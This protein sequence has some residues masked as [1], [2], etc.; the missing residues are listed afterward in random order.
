MRDKKILSLNEKKNFQILAISGGGYRG[1]YSAL[2]L[3]KI[4]QKAGRP[5]AQCFDLICGTSI[6]GIIALAIGME[7]PMKD[8]VQM[9][10]EKGPKIF[11]KPTGFFSRFKPANL[12][13]AFRSKYPQN[14]LKE[15]LEGI[16]ESHIVGDIAVKGHRV[17]IPSVN[18]TQSKPQFF[19]TPH[20]E[21]FSNDLYLKLVDVSLATSAAPPFLPMHH[22]KNLGFFIDGGIVGNAPELFGMHEATQFLG[23][24][25]EEIKVLGIG[26]LDQMI[27]PKADQRSNAGWLEWGMGKKLFALTITGQQQVMRHIVKQKLGKRYFLIDRT[28]PSEKANA[29]ELDDANAN[30][31][32]ML[33][34]EAGTSIQEELSKPELLEFLKHQPQ[35]A[36]FFHLNYGVHC[37]IA[38]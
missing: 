6:G 11:K 32:R 23:M 17:L 19:K 10:T 7:I 22:I 26:T 29:L 20:H 25:E 34:E 31:T 27:V 16:F 38:L 15:A 9:L 28:V 2:V 8:I 4:E 24:Y 21:A 1:L 5:L 18:F 33:R 30:S 35:K 14:E 36:K 3:E 12:S 37:P 13:M